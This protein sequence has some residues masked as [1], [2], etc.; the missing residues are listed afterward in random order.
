MARAITNT[1]VVNREPKDE[2]IHRLQLQ[3]AELQDQVKLAKEESGRAATEEVL[4]QLNVV[5]AAYADLQ[6]EMVRVRLLVLGAT[7]R[8]QCVLHF[9]SI[10][11]L[12]KADVQLNSPGQ[13]SGRLN[14]I[15]C[16]LISCPAQTTNMM[17][18]QLTHTPS[19]YLCSCCAL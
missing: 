13:M 1:P 9:V 8:L 4:Q 2:L 14:T 19:L 6:E 15:A 18:I 5:E 7:E 17:K 16:C 12:H 11:T 10:A 3:L